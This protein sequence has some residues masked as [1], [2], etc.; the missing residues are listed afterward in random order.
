MTTHCPFRTYGAALLVLN[1]EDHELLQM[2]MKYVRPHVKT[3]NKE[4]LVTKSGMKLTSYK[5]FVR[6][7]TT[8]FGITNFPSC[9]EVRKAGA[10]A[11]SGE[12][13]KE[14]M[15]VLSEHMTHSL[16]TSQKY[17]RSRSRIEVAKQVHKAI[18]GVTG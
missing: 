2:Y 12:S 15:T 18:A 1:E 5:D 11:M 3:Q 7:L 14:E 13:S 4:A 17:Y 6:S 16:P 9:T 10:T 8:R